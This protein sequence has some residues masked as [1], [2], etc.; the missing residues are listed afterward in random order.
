MNH[1]LAFRG[2]KYFEEGK[3]VSL[4]H[5]LIKPSVRF[6]IHYFIRLG[7]LDGF[8]GL[9]F[10]KIQAYSVF[11]KYVKLWLLNKGIK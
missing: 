11:V 7:F 2:K 4:F 6:V 10:A 9:F 3:K 8:T 1:Y 5:I